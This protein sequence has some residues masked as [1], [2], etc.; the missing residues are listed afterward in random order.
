MTGSKKTLEDNIIQ[1][2]VE[3]VEY[4]GSG[5]T[6][7]VPIVGEQGDLEGEQV[8][9]IEIVKSPTN[10]QSAIQHDVVPGPTTTPTTTTPV[11][12]TV[13][14][15]TST[16]PLATVAKTPPTEQ[17]LANI[18]L[19]SNNNQVSTTLFPFV[20]VEV[21]KA[22]EDLNN[23]NMKK[24]DTKN[25]PDKIPTPTPPTITTT[26]PIP[27]INTTPVPPTLTTTPTTSQPKNELK[28]QLPVVPVDQHLA[29]GQQK[30]NT[31]NTTTSESISK[32]HLSTAIDMEKSNE[33]LKNQPNDAILIPGGNKRKITNQQNISQGVLYKDE[34]ASKRTHESAHILEDNLDNSFEEGLTENESTETFTL[35]NNNKNNND[36]FI[37]ERNKHEI[38]PYT[39]NPNLDHKPKLNTP[40]S[41]LWNRETTKHLT[42]PLISNSTSSTTTDEKK[43]KD[44][45]GDKR[46]GVSQHYSSFTESEEEEEMIGNKIGENKSII[47]SDD[48]DSSSDKRVLQTGDND[49]SSGKGVVQQEN[50][51]MGSHT[52]PPAFHPTKALNPESHLDGLIRPT[53]VPNQFIVSDDELISTSLK[54]TKMAEEKGKGRQ[55]VVPVMMANQQQPQQQVLVSP[56]FTT[57]NQQQTQ[58][59][60]EHQETLKTQP[61]IQGPSLQ[62]LPLQGKHN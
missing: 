38:K 48:R 62:V 51:K 52:T 6:S 24:N 19:N 36:N 18:K 45:K 16:T 57:V 29:P 56:M 35:V 7:A 50:D 21:D 54:K 28:P 60:E 42:A 39:P 14:T 26:T 23:N 17:T 33:I 31:T 13:V 41:A 37:Q 2:H 40:P 12:V 1:E 22:P 44:E 4:I 49:S 34:V 30:L 55:L 8:E 25:E 46:A 11:V 32:K 58:P 15:G 59:Q 5:E 3:H 47:Q 10:Q 20:T 27:P 53:M 61:M 43:Y 9:T